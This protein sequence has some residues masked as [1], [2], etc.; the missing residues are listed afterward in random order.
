MTPLP[1]VLA[2]LVVGSNWASTLGGTSR[3]LRT[4]E[5]RER[6][7]ALRNSPNIGAI[8]VGSASA[9][10]EPYQKS[11]H[12]LFVYSR[13]SAVTPGEFINQVRRKISGSI[14]CEGGV[15]LLHHLLSENCIDQFHLTRA[16]ALGDGHY[17][18]IELL[19]A[20][21]SLSASEVVNGTTFEKYERASR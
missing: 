4:S 12:P 21:M 18:D 6:F 2:S 1:T 13:S 8:I 10:V 3:G 9:L 7:L 11:P 16:P 15:T 20:S 5:D 19:R 17:F 14:L